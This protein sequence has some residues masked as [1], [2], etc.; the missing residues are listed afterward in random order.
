MKSFSRL[1]L[2]AVTLIASATLAFAQAPSGLVNKL[3]LQKLI[4]AGTPEAN[5]TLANHFSALANT[6]T[7]DAARHKGMAQAYNANS[8]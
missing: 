1:A 4:A 2:V 7:A 5:A 8:N 3:E 6:Y